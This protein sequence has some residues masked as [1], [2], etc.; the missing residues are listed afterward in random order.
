MRHSIQKQLTLS[1]CI[2]GFAILV[3]P[4][5]SLVEKLLLRLAPRFLL[6]N[7]LSITR[8]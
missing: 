7:N 4:T 5:S 2:V 6:A 3:G 1:L 8:H